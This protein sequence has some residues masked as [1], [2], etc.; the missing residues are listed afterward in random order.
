MEVK[1]GYILWLKKLSD[2]DHTLFQYYPHRPEFYNHP[3]LV[4]RAREGS[5]EVDVCLVNSP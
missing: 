4:V 5:K 2:I 3:V 1:E